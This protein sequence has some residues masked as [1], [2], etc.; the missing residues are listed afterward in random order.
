MRTQ[1]T[2]SPPPAPGGEPPPGREL[3]GIP[4]LIAMVAAILLFTAVSIFIEVRQNRGSGPYFAEV[5]VVSRVRED[6]VR[7]VFHVRNE[8]EVP[9]RPDK[10]EAQLLNATGDRVGT[11]TV[12]VEEEI[13]PGGTLDVQGIGTVADQPV[14]GVARCR[15]LEPT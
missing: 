8:G 10:C 6:A 1:T 11:A 7:V 3:L 4:A 12:D 2:D 5:E 15:A 14:N 9:G 13:P